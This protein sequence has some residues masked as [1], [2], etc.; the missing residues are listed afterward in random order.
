MLKA[1][2]ASVKNHPVVRKPAIQPAGCRGANRR[3]VCGQIKRLVELRTTLEKIR[4]I[5]QKLKYQ[6]DKLLKTAAGAA[7]AEV[8]RVRACCRS[9]ASACTLSRRV[10]AG[11]PQA[12]AASRRAGG[13]RRWRRR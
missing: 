12:Q 3:V 4:P 13:Q 11:R 2:G 8:R 9:P 1:E 10:A 7:A 6:V 5:D